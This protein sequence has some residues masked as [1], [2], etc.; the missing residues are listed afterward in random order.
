AGFI[1]SNLLRRLDAMGCT[2]VVVLDD[3]SLGDRRAIA[4]W[5][6]EFVKGD[7]RDARCLERCLAGAD[8]VVHLAA[9]TRV[10]DSIADPVKNYEVNVQGTFQLLDL[11]R[12]HGVRRIVVASTGGAILGD[13]EPPIDEDRVARPLAP[14]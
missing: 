10:M 14:Y 9:D 2:G 6:H 11:A 5:R 8:I 13:A 4:P 1:G 7:I 12:R 3:E